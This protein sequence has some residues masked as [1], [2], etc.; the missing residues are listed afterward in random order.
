MTVF[1]RV[2]AVIIGRNEGDRLKACLASVQ[3]LMGHVVYV[4]SGSTD[5]STSFARG[6]GAQVVE[7]EKSVP[8]TAARARNAGLNAL[9][10]AVPSLSFVQFIDGDCMLQSDWPAI[11]TAFLEANPNV[12]V[13]C[14]RRR[15][16]MPGASIYNRMCDWEWDTPIGKAKACGGD[17]LMRIAALQSVNGFN[18]TLIAGEEPELCLRLR[19]SG[20]QIWR[21]DV[22]MTLHDAAMLSVVQWWR[23]GVRGGHARA[24]GMALHGRM[25]AHH[26]VKETLRALAW[27]LL[28]PG[29]TAGLALVGVS[30]AWLLLLAYPAQAVRLARVFGWDQLVSW[31][32]AGLLVMV[33]FP[34]AIG[35][36]EYWSARLRNRRVALIEY[37]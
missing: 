18:P 2:G 21:L 6:V 4:D 32:R 1:D 31:Q 37:K 22:E 24:E 9:S 11:A 10:M 23:R 15:E 27:A 8:F 34:E 33:K 35:I 28:L 13:A 20:W 17:A 3:G 14:G 29:A 12:A 5:E 26:G 25:P 7:L 30:W 19:Q 16:R 36:L